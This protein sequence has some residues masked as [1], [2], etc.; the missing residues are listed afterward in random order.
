MPCMVAMVTVVVAE[1]AIDDTDGD[2]HTAI[3]IFAAA[4]SGLMRSRCLASHFWLQ[5]Y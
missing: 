4:T 5:Q 1:V 2:L 3:A